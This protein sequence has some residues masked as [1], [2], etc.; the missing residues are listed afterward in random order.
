MT[1][2]RKKM[3]P[4]TLEMLVLLKANKEF[5]QDARTMQGILDEQ[6]GGDELP[7]PDDDDEEEEDINEF[8]L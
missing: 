4:D 1:S 7:E 5:W 6:G 2:L 8:D 3:D